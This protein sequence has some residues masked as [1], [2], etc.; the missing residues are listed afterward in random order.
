[1]SLLSSAAFAPAKINLFLEVT[2][3]RADGY[4]LLDSLVVFAGIGDE[5]EL[6]AASD[7]NL[8]ITGPFAGTL[9]G[10]GDNLVLRA[11]RGLAEL[12][13]R[14]PGVAI[15]LIKRLPVASGI[16]GGSSD[17]AATIRALVRYWNLNIPTAA[18]YD[19][20]L[21]LGAD[22]PVCLMARPARMSGIGEVLTPL[23]NL[24]PL[25]ILLV[26]AGHPVPT[27]AIFKHPSLS[28]SPAQ[29][30]E[31]PLGST[32]DLISWLK[33]RRNDLEGPA[34]VVE[35]SVA[36]VLQQLEGLPGAALV[37][38]SGSGGT[39]FALF[40]SQA[41]AEQAAQIL[42]AKEP[43]WWITAAPI[44]GDGGPNTWAEPQKT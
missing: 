17:A 1:M 35:P 11:A 25:W 30:F 40:E 28:F 8:R 41:A 44:L 9:S 38:M 42:V 26:N 32:A 15:H 10:E 19:F 4:H 3:R 34:R 5:V 21:R 12:A 23:T 2:A 13:G 29:A 36:H 37:R 22:L 6:Q 14:R 43:G 18:L 16:G 27:G 33:T 24:P 31:P 20:A 7:L 39:C